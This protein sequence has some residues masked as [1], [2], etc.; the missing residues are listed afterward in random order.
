MEELERD[1]ISDLKDI[2]GPLMEKIQDTEVV[3]EDN[4]TVPET[5]KVERKDLDET[6]ISKTSRISTGVPGLDE[7]LQGGFVPNSTVLV[8]GE[9]GTGK[10]IFC[11]QFIWNALC[12]GENGV[13]VTLQQSPEEIKNDVLP[14]GRDFYS[15][16]VRGQARIIY[17]EPTDDVNKVVK[18]ILK[19][20][21]DVGAKRLVVDSI[22]L[23]GEQ[24]KDV[25]KSLS[26]LVRELKTI[27]VTTVITSEVEEGSKKIS[28]FGI[29]EFIV[30]GVIILRCGADIVGDRPRSL[31]I[32]K[33]R[34]T[35][36][37][38]HYHPFE[39]TERGIRVI[40]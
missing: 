32:K 40:R 15:A 6:K 8:T 34:R 27:G 11:T 1:E 28:K 20:V 23:I 37:D 36:H 30:D 7:K 3:E 2:S 25:R 17:I 39:I 29:E 13:Y 16:E 5:R 21:K 26:Y 4:F 14:F 24:A 9:A 31:Q 10:T 33:M 22:T 35:K 38:L 18:E 19:H 12:L